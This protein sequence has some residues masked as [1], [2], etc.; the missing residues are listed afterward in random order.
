[1]RPGLGVVPTEAASIFAAGP[2]YGSAA[3][4]T[5]V[6]YIFNAGETA[7]SITS[8]LI[9]DEVANDYSVVS[10]NCGTS[11]AKHR[12]CRTVAR[13]FEGGAI[14]C[15]ATVSNATNLRGSLEVRDADGTVLNS[16]QLR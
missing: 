12:S 9:F 1:M 11:L 5:G 14:S 3:Q 10:N 2:I 6:C 4:V 8:I 15:R 13:I 16:V 7:V